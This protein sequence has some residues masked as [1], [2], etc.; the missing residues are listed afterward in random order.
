LV[1]LVGW[2]GCFDCFGW[3]VCFFWLVG[4]LFWLVWLC[5]VGWFWFF[6]L[7]VC[8]VWFVGWSFAVV[9]RFWA[10]CD[11]IY[12]CIVLSCPLLWCGDHLQLRRLG[13]YWII[14][15]MVMALKKAFDCYMLLCA[16]NALKQI[17]FT[18]S[19][20]AMYMYFYTYIWSIHTHTHTHTLL[21]SSY[22]CKWIYVLDDAF[23]LQKITQLPR[24]SVIR[25][26]NL[27]ITYL[28]I[29]AYFDWVQVANIC[30]VVM[31]LWVPP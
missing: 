6:W 17:L 24:N 7:V 25:I 26:L 20:A 8:L 21:S 2:F 14:L 11:S 30:V 19:W 22:I 28:N 1:G 13:L 31:K 12:E 29:N 27:I 15:A 3:L 4:W 23:L 9:K 16:S 5:W 18:Y 10:L